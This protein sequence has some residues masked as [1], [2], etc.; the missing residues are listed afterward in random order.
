MYSPDFVGKSSKETGIAV[1]NMV[2]PNFEGFLNADADGINFTDVACFS[3]VAKISVVSLIGLLAIASLVSQE[4]N[5]R[6][7]K[8][9]RLITLI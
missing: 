8:N 3:V 2:S 9:I 4:N 5:N 1:S 7:E 6:S